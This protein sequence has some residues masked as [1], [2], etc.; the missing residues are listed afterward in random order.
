[1]CGE[2]Y[3]YVCLLR[4]HSG[5]LSAWIHGGLSIRWSCFALCESPSAENW[6]TAAV[7]FVRFLPCDWGYWLAKKLLHTKNSLLLS[8]LIFSMNA[9]KTMMCRSHV[10]V[11]WHNCLVRGEGNIVLDG[12]FMKTG[13]ASTRGSCRQLNLNETWTKAQHVNRTL[14]RCCLAKAWQYID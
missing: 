7:A 2:T 5:R 3:A 1:M 9:W 8:L 4:T 11:R 10:L 12:V 13:R 14:K 6:Q